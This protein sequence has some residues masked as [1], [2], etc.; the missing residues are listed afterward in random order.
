MK[1]ILLGLNRFNQRLFHTFFIQGSFQAKALLLCAIVFWLTLAGC[2]VAF[3]LFDMALGEAL[4]WAWSHIMDPGFIGDDREVPLRAIIGSALSIVGLVVVGGTLIALASDLALS[5]IELM[6]KGRI[7]SGIQYHTVIFG[8]GAMVNALV[9][10]MRPDRESSTNQIVVVL[11]S[12]DELDK[13][14]TT[15]SNFCHYCVDDRWNPETFDRLNLKQ[16]DR[17]ILLE[18]FGGN[19]SQRIQ[20]IMY[21]TA[22][23]NALSENK[24]NLKIYTEVNDP[25]VL[26]NLR[27]AI[28]QI[29]GTN[30]NAEI[31]LLNMHELCARLALKQYFLDL[32]PTCRDSDQHIVF[33]IDGWNNLSQALFWQAVKTAHYLNKP[34]RLIVIAEQNELVEKCIRSNAP[35]LCDPRY[36]TWLIKVDVIQKL[37]DADWHEH[38]QVTLALCGTDSDSVFSR[39]L[40]CRQIARSGLRQILVELPDDSGYRGLAEMLPSQVPVFAIGSHLEAFYLAD[41]LDRYAREAHE[42]Y[43]SNQ[44]SRPKNPDGSYIQSNHN[45]WD[46]LSENIRSANRATMDHR[47]IKLHALADSLGVDRPAHTNN[48]TL[49]QTLQDKINELIQ[50]V[51][52][53]R[54]EPSEVLE[55][56]AS[57]EHDRW[58]GEKL[59]EGWVY[60]ESK[61]ITRKH[62]PYLVHYDELTEEVKHWDRVQVRMQLST[63]LDQGSQS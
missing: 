60:G 22:Q 19:L 49:I 17:I 26:S 39:A 10:N 44:T 34:T 24:K 51:D 45:D 53:N 55:S 4:F 29:K 57:L 32:F 2:I 36:A 20:L 59:A 5:K 23:R 54:S 62:S 43:L 63:F 1:K 31:N 16:A 50:H 42:R 6:R 46:N 58:S 27:S 14:D 52:E 9:R 41:S 33:I 61:D 38:D 3:T 18:N 40:H 11:P 48:P 35:G 28:P 12:S 15:H 7:P 21:V 37:T 25:E 30:A 56:L 47:W 8:T 13:I